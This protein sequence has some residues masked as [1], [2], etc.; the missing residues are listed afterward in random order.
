M[1]F[2]ITTIITFINKTI[3]FFTS[4]SDKNL[5]PIRVRI[6]NKHNKLNNR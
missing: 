1:Q 3:V 6:Q 5:E 2:Y 4:G